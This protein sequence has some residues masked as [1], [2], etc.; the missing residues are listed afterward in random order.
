MADSDIRE[1][2]NKDC[3][4]GGLCQACEKELMEQYQGMLETNRIAAEC[5]LP[6]YAR[7]EEALLETCGKLDEI[8]ERIR[9]ALERR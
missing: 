5:V 6:R 9:E 3:G 7:L 1:C 2:T 4:S 8:K